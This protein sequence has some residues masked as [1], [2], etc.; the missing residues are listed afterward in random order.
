MNFKEL[1]FKKL[2]RERNASVWSI[3]SFSIYALWNL[4]CTHQSL[5]IK[6]FSKWELCVLFNRTSNMVTSWNTE[7]R[8]RFFFP[9]HRSKL[10]IWWRKAVCVFVYVNKQITK[11]IR[12]YYKV[13]NYANL[14]KPKQKYSLYDRNHR[15]RD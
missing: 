14:E 8:N 13:F 3:D 6:V 4:V 10:Q 11:V 1:H 2:H 9:V 7:Y 15:W 5:K 12:N